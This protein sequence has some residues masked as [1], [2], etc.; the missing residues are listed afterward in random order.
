[1]INT[2]IAVAK[3]IKDLHKF[4]YE[5]ALSDVFSGG[6]IDSV[7]TI[8]K[9][10]NRYSS[11]ELKEK[12]DQKIYNIEGIS[13]ELISEVKNLDTKIKKLCRE[14]VR[15]QHGNKYEVE[16]LLMMIAK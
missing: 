16:E 1:M 13:I 5:Q 15:Y 3:L 11:E 6:G 2:S 12:K 10:I 7:Q 14:S 8:L 9:L 4:I